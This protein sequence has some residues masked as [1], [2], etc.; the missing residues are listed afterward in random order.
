MGGNSSR[1]FFPI[2]SNYL[3]DLDNIAPL[4]SNWFFDKIWADIGMW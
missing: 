4:D 2:Y 3:M 1:F